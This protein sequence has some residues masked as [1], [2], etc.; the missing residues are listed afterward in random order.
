MP[1]LSEVLRDVQSLVW[2]ND[3][4][5]AD[6]DPSDFFVEAG[7]VISERALN[8]CRG[9]PVRLDCVRHA[10]NHKI[11]GGYFGGLSPGQRR[12]MTLEQ[13]ERFIA[14]DPPQVVTGD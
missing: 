2:L 11:I 5:C 1:D 7:H 12:D 9:C 14:N 4:A 6:M 10:Y 3:A 8:V 13:A